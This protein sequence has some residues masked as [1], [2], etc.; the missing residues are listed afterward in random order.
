MAV[1]LACI[2]NATDLRG[3]PIG[4]LTPEHVAVQEDGQ[5]A[6]IIDFRGEEL[7]RPVDIVVVFDVTESMGPFI[8]GMKGSGH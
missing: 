3:Q 1:P 5:D 8:D 6:Q 2:F 4:Q 7:G